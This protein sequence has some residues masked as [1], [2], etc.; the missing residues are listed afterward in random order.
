MHLDDLLHRLAIGKADVVEEAAAQERVGQFLLVVRGDDHD[1][2]LPRRHGLARLVDVE[3]HAVELEQEIV[4]EFDVG[5]VD[6][7]DQQHRRR[8]G[9]EGLPELA[10][11]NV[12][13]D[14]GDLRLAELAVAQPRHRVVF[15]EPLLRLGRRLDVPGDEVLAERLGDLLRQD[16]LAGA[17]LALD[18]QRP[19][20]RDRGVDG[21][22][23]ILRRDIGFG[24]LKTLHI[25][26][27]S[28]V[29][30]AASTPCLAQL[31]ARRHSHLRDPCARPT[32]PEV[33]R[34]PLLYA[35]L[36]PLYRLFRRNS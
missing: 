2:P 16:G 26:L 36:R 25:G 11:L 19:L 30:D 6:L 8:V 28:K 34:V 10:A 12:V 15:V 32:L 22:A 5:L 1:R 21:D 33:K 31:D 27:F 13:G 4:G 7:V 17:G 23:K 29:R 35:R 24:A 14:V 3:L 20:Q 18:Q 9:G